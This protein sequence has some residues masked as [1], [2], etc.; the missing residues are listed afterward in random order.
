MLEY[1]IKSW[2]SVIPKD[3]TFPYPMIYIKPDKKFSDYAKENDYTVMITVSGT[4]SQ[5]DN[6]KTIAIIDSSGYFPDYRPHFFNKT[7]FLVLTL[8]CG[9]LGYPPT[10]GKVLIQ[11]LKG[12][13]AVTLIEK[14][15]VAP[16]PIEWYTPEVEENCNDCGNR[17]NP[18]Q[19]S[20]LCIGFLVVFGVL[21][22]NGMKKK[23]VI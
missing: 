22:V 2:N 4:G 17:L 15:F 13:D 7:G 19:I 11:G 21:V 8:M 6:Q 18:T 16:K 5:Y 14:P 10:N 3:N 12:E 23:A 1:E 9:W 20:I